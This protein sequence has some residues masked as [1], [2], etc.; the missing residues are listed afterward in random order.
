ML[1][2][3]YLYLFFSIEILEQ[4]GLGRLLHLPTLAAEP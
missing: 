4:G 3:T 2:F 1:C